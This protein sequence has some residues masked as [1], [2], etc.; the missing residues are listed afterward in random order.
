MSYNQSTGLVEINASSVRTIELQTDALSSETG[1][2][3]C[4]QCHLSNVHAINGVNIQATSQRAIAASNHT[5]ANSNTLWPLALST[6]STA[7]STS[8]IFHSS[9]LA[10]SAAL[11]NVKPNLYS[12]TV[13]A[14][15]LNLTSGGVIR[16]GSNAILDSDS[17][18]DY[19]WLKNAPAFSNGNDVLGATGVALG[20]LGLLGLAGQQLLSQTGQLGP[21]V[22]ADLAKKL[23]EEAVDEA[24]DPS[25]SESNIQVHYNAIL[26]PPVHKNLNSHDVGFASNVFIN[27]NACLYSIRA[28]DLTKVDG[29]RYKRIAA[30]PSV[31]K[32]I[33]FAQRDFFGRNFSACNLTAS[34]NITC[35]NLLT[36]AVTCP[37]VGT[38]NLT[39]TNVSTVNSACSNLTTASLWC[40]PSGVWTQN[41]AL[42]PL[43]AVQVLDQF[44]RYLG[45]VNASQV[46][47][48]ESLD[49][50]SLAD[51]VL[52]LQGNAT[53]YTSP[54]ASISETAFFTLT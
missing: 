50:S 36:N 5:Y 35:D 25:E 15:N 24:F 49:F 27:S 43:S 1:I 32:C 52:Q 51:G 54:F 4:M 12:Q 14:C 29:G 40:G 31:Q 30:G 13:S 6:A 3:D 42:Y 44:G 46:I 2:V 23:G 39:A 17:R 10:A 38:S 34:N 21:S 20:A 41:P 53:Q 18:I 22:A 9:F 47:N 16:V 45:T 37:T 28:S 26:Y 8:N 48:T 19:K 11:S 7:V 33:D